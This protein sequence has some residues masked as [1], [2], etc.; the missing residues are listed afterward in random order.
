MLAARDT[1]INGLFQHLGISSLVKKTRYSKVG[2]FFVND[3]DIV[4]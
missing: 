4:C 2:G 3:V 1:G